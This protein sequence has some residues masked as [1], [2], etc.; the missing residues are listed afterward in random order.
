MTSQASPCPEMPWAPRE[1]QVSGP[2]EVQLQAHLHIRSPNIP[3]S[4]GQA[5]LQLPGTPQSSPQDWAGAG[6]YAC[7]PLHPRVLSPHSCLCCRLKSRVLNLNSHLKG[8]LL[9]SFCLPLFHLRLF[10]R[11]HKSS[12]CPIDTMLRPVS[13]HRLRT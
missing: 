12:L 2:R 8:T 3:K 4:R 1:K 5:A 10:S 7:A 9:H 6:S 13:L 11:Y